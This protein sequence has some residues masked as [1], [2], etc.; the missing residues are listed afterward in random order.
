MKSNERVKLLDKFDKLNFWLEHTVELHEYNSDWEKIYN[1]EKLRI[2]EKLWK[3]ISIY[4]VWSTSIKWLCAKPIIDILVTYNNWYEEISKKLLELGY[5]FRKDLFPKRIYYVLE[6]DKWVRFFA[7][8][9][10]KNWDNRI[11]WPLKF[12][13]NV[14]W[15]SDLAKEYIDLKKK[16]V[17]KHLDSRCDYTKMKSDFILKYSE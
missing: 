14:E 17:K 16:S 10:Y 3:D 15:N 7:L 12:K 2:E 8:S 4:H 5:V 9:V 6:N 11:Y 13:N 1:D